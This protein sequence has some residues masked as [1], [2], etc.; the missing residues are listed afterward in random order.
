MP[1]L[2]PHRDPHRAR[3]PPRDGRPRVGKPRVGKP[4]VG[5]PR[6]CGVTAHAAFGTGW[7]GPSAQGVS[8]A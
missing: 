7:R 6:A 5:K 4:R 1:E 8:W 3:R 2:S